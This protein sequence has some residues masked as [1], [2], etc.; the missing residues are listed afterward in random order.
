MVLNDFTVEFSITETHIQSFLSRNQFPARQW[1][2]LQEEMP[3]SILSAV[4]A[5]VLMILST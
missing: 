2:W 1:L 3:P 5:F 4:A